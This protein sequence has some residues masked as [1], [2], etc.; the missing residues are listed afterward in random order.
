MKTLY[1][2]RIENLKFYIQSQLWGILSNLNNKMQ[3]IDTYI[4]NRSEYRKMSK[5]VTEDL[6]LVDL[7]L[8]AYKK[9]GDKTYTE[10]DFKEVREFFACLIK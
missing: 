2:I 8:K 4:N 10:E 6:R 5:V 7:Y 3:H 9:V 1:D